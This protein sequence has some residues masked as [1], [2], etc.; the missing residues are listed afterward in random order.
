MGLAGTSKSVYCKKKKVSI[1]QYGI[2]LL[3]SKR[4]GSTEKSVNGDTVHFI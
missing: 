3:S 4:M 2:C 1:C